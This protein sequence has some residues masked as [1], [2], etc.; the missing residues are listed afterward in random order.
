M[1]LSLLAAAAAQAVAS[2]P[3]PD[4]GQSIE[5]QRATVLDAISPCRRAMTDE[6]IVVCGERN[7]EMPDLAGG[8]D[9]SMPVRRSAP[10]E[11]GAWFEV[12]RGPLSLTCC[13]V[14]GSGG[15]GAGIALRLDF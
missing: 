11:R 4:A 8:P 14:G 12:R 2:P 9:G 13:S 6:E 10:P 5:R 3:P 15:T 7:S 1:T